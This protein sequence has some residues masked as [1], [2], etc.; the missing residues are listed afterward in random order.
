MTDF[1]PRLLLLAAIAAALVGFG[2]ITMHKHDAAVLADLQR[3]YSEFKGGV[4]A[5]GKAAEKR[6][7]EI[8][9]SNKLTKEKADRENAAAVAA[10]RSTIAGLQSERA[11]RGSAGGFVSQPAPDALG[12][13]IACYDS[14]KLDDALRKL[15]SGVQ[16]LVDEGSKAVT[17]LDSARRWAASVK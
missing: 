17:D 6:K 11:K 8:E 2:A 16:G 9:L 13:R 4:E 15:D 14:A 5:L 1:L 10:L 12:L 7:A 3:Q